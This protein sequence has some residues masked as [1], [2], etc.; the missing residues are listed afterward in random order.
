[1]NNPCISNGA[2]TAHAVEMLV[3]DLAAILRAC[4][5]RGHSVLTSSACL[6]TMT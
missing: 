6:T 1:M 5:A 2:S 3:T 4:G